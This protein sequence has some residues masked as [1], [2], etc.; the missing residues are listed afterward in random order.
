MSLATR[1]PAP[2][3][4]R[5]SSLTAAEVADV[6]PEPVR[7]RE[8]ELIEAVKILEFLKFDEFVCRGG[9][10]GVECVDEQQNGKRRA[11]YP[12][13]DIDN[14]EGYV[15]SR[16]YKSSADRNRTKLH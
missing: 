3:F 6:A 9:R 8:G 7:E 16:P 12:N 15:H 1:T 11:K 5:A 2:L 13:Q 14:Q 4:A 10:H